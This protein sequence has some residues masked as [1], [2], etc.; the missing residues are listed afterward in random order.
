VQVI[1]VQVIYV[2]VIYVRVIYVRVIYVRVIYVQVMCWVDRCVY[3]SISKNTRVKYN[4]LCVEMCVPFYCTAF[5]FKYFL[6][7]K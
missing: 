4:A 5:F 6:P 1:Y 7:E 3:L 2:Q